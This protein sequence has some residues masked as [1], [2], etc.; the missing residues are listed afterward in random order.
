M[1]DIVV[2]IPAYKP[3]IDIM[4]T[5]LKEL[6]KSFKNV[7]IVNDGSGKEF[8]DF[9]NEL[10]K[11]NIV[12]IKHDVNK[13]KGRAIKTG[14]EYIL[15]NYSNIT[16]TITADCDGQHTVSDIE[17][18]AISLRKNHNSLIIGCRNF[19]EPQTP[20]R[21]K[22]GNN[23]TKFIFIIFIG[24][25]ISD[26]QSGLR[27]F[28][29]E[30]MKKFLKTNGE[31]YEY[32]TNMLIDCKN[33]NIEIF[34]VPI[35][36]IYINNNATSHFNPIKDSF[37]IYK[38]FF[39]YALA[40]ISSF[41]IDMI[42]FCIFTNWI[43]AK[44]GNN[45][46]ISTIIARIL[47]SIYNFMTNSKLV[48]KKSRKSSIY[49][50]ITLVII[51]MFVSG[52]CVSFLSEHVMVQVPLLKLLIDTVIFM[53]NFVVQREWIFK[54]EN[55]NLSD[56]QRKRVLL[57]H[58]PSSG[59]FKNKTRYKSIL[60]K[61]NQ[62]DCIFDIKTTTNKNGAEEIIN[63]EK[64]KYDYLCICGGDGTLNQTVSALSKNPEKKAP[65]IYSPFGTTNDF[66]KSI[67]I[68]KLKSKKV[69]HGNKK[70][71]TGEING[72]N[73]FNYIVAAGLFTETSY[74]TSR[75]AKRIFGRFAYFYNGIKELFSIK[76]Y[77]VNVTFNNKNIKDKFVYMAVSNSYSIGG[78]RIFKKNEID[79]DDGKFEVFLVKKPKNFFKLIK[80]GIKLLLKNHKDENIIFE[81][82]DSI[83]I[84]TQERISWTFDGEK[85]NKYNE[86]N[87]K[88]ICRNI[89]FLV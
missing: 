52:F 16:G 29:P 10:E 28:S 34:E 17:K 81:Q 4:R 2:L 40:A 56:I 47:S 83:K 59:T 69:L 62:Y 43:F 48:F 31:R 24:V 5:F 73:Y 1:E 82:T 30:L 79:L 26:T 19:S 41:A 8:D 13:G 42:L 63:N 61:L 15:N 76:E 39:K 87:I 33:S 77:H 49:K 53:V 68:E 57:I 3:N 74:N 32:E 70:T 54:N 72:N 35:E 22:L 6:K 12:V 65:I 23:L 75:K 27:A 86:L 55:E 84:E 89:E 85:S 44:N 45:I 37:I 9:Y 66:A 60:R 21:S 18:C 67:K 50:Y 20:L 25:N 51:Q 88:N 80:T 78:F 36:T 14:F 7:V 38:Q 58:N 46:M 11:D 71:D 64:E